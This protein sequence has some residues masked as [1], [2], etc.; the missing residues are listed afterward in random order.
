MKRTRL[1]RCR[2]KLT[3]ALVAIARQR[4]Q[5]TVEASAPVAEPEVVVETVAIVEAPVLAV[6][7][8]LEPEPVAFVTAEQVAEAAAEEEAPEEI[9]EAT[10]AEAESVETGDGVET[11]S[12]VSKK[13]RPRRP[14]GRRFARSRIRVGAGT[15]RTI[16]A[17]RIAAHAQKG[18]RWSAGSARRP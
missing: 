15:G 12:A 14:R 18:T 6:E 4:E 11:E 10:D 17:S 1:P 2:P 9:V 8:E 16:S 13:A 3:R 5:P 7:P